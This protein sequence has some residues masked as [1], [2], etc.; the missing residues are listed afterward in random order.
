MAYGNRNHGYQRPAGNAPTAKQLSFLNDLISRSGMTREQWEDQVGLREH[1][2]WGVRMRSEL[3][4]RQRVSIW[5]D[6]LK[7]R[8]GS[9]TEMTATHPAD[10][11]GCGGE[12][13]P[14]GSCGRC[15][16]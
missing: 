16:P 13:C 4:T 10:P 15:Q 1:S 7:S 8:Q 9:L 11:H 6:A 2:P 12:F 14:D 5:I 3:V